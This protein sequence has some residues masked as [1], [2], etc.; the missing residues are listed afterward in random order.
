MLAARLPALMSQLPSAHAR[1]DALEQ[2]CEQAAEALARLENVP[3]GR[4]T[5]TGAQLEAVATA[6]RALARLFSAYVSV[7]DDATAVRARRPVG[8]SRQAKLAALRA[9]QFAYR[10][11]LLACRSYTDFGP[12]HWRPMV[13]LYRLAERRDFHDTAL[14]ADSGESISRH[15]GRILLLALADA[16]GM[17]RKALEATRFYVERYGHLT[18]ICDPKQWKESREGWFVAWPSNAGVR[19]LLHKE[20]LNRLREPDML[21]LD[22]HPLLLKLDSHRDGLAAGTSPTRLGLPLNARDQDYVDLLARLRTQWSVPQLRRQVRRRALP[23]VELVAG[24]DQIRQFM[25]YVAVLRNRPDAQELSPF[26]CSEWEVLDRSAEGL[27]LQHIAEE[28]IAIEVGEIVAI[29]QIEM[30]EVQL[31]VARRTRFRNNHET[32]LGL[33]LL[34]GP[35]I[36]ARFRPPKKGGGKSDS[37]ADAVPI[38]FL[39]SVPRLNDS[40]GLL[41]PRGMVEAGTPIALPHRRGV[42]RFTA[43]ECVERFASCELIRLQQAQAPEPEAF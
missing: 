38:L 2:I 18:R 13:E 34:C 26:P 31:A 20:D 11:A 7:V 23:R 3:E 14:T 40:P 29:Q 4:G 19:P 12:E 8:V 16:Q 10:R 41:A 39:P 6:D 30:A 27:G 25:K 21:L 24:F 1:F 32:D 28:P 17:T 5:M 9:S 36:A 35:G 43:V 22:A 37:E 42:T 15:L 33:E